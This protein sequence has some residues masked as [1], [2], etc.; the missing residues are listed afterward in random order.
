[1]TK[2]S[3]QSRQSRQA[4]TSEHLLHERA[5]ALGFTLAKSTS[6]SYDSALASY[7][8]FCRL[9]NLA[10]TPTPDTF[11]FYAVWMSAYILPTSVDVYLSGICNKLEDEFPEICAALAQV[12]V[13]RGGSRVW[14]LAG[15]GAGWDFE[16]RDPRTRHFHIWSSAAATA[17]VCGNDEDLYQVIA[18][19]R[20]A[21]AVHPVGHTDW[22]SSLNDLGNQLSSRFQ[23]RGNREDLNESREN[24]CCALTLLTQHDP[25]QL[26][27]HNSLAKVYLSFHHSGLDG[28]GVGEDTNSL[29]SAMHHL[30]ATAN[31]VSRGSL[32]RLR[33]SLCWV[34]YASQHSH[35][36]ELEAYATSM[37]LLDAY[38]S[39]TAS[40]SS[41][42]NIMKD[43]PRTLAM[44]AASCA[45]RSGDITRLRTPLDSLQTRGDH[46]AALMKKFRDLS[47][48][49]DNP[50]ANNR[51]ATTRVHVEAEEARYS[52]Q[53]S[54]RFR[55]STLHLLSPLSHTHWSMSLTN[56]TTQ[57]S[58]RFCHRG[59]NEDLDEAI[60][61]HTEALALRLVS[62]T[63][64][65]LSLATRLSTHFHHR[66][67][68]EGS[69]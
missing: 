30:K 49:L 66:G 24:L 12:W 36:T 2:V 63:D 50:P 42:H 48:L 64:R 9:H 34:Q 22:S 3:H 61:L 56:L 13:T 58:T 40:V 20:E 45:L 65:P 26:V 19:Q 39:T 29:N 5:I 59:N 33:A 67:N 17:V 62:H 8:E 25:R 4:W 37:Q 18:L 7:I 52:L 28:T 15:M 68:D 38:M 47:S 69:D 51:E 57:L 53:L 41:R 6:A 21:L 44:D 32:S 23:H 1:M 60:A 55:H 31:V 27:V 11:S 10:L 43:F 16:T 54:T 46:A 35:A 14:V